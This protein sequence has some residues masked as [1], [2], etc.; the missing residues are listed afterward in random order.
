[1]S[2]PRYFA[3]S[4]SPLSV[5]APA[6]QAEANLGFATDEAR[7]AYALPTAGQL[8]A[9]DE[10]SKL[11]RLASKAFPDLTITVGIASTRSTSKGWLGRTY[12][13]RAEGQAL[14]EL[15]LE[16]KGPSITEVINS[17]IRQ[18]ATERARATAMR[19]AAALERS[20]RAA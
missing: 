11:E 15:R 6:E 16:A 1:M 12:V 17:M 5:A 7:P 3:T 18:V 19:E 2:Q 10:F 8:P 14:R 4:R 20:Q 9:E 13:L